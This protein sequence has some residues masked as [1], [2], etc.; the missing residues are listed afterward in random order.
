[1]APRF[2][3]KDLLIRSI[4]VPRAYNNREVRVGEYLEHGES[5]LDFEHQ[6]ERPDL[7]EEDCDVEL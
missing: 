5:V 6:G 2:G 3:D 1:M 7:G 4:E